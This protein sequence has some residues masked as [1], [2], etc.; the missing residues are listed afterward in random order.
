[1]GPQG[2]PWRAE[3]LTVLTIVTRRHMLRF[4]MFVKMRLCCSQVTTVSAGPWAIY[5]RHFGL[6][7]SLKVSWNM[8]S[9]AWNVKSFFEWDDFSIHGFSGHFWTGNVFRNAHMCNL[10]CQHA[11]SQRVQTFLVCLLQR[12]HSRRISKTGLYQQSFPSTSSS[13]RRLKI[14]VRACISNCAVG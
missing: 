2:I 7:K 9:S 3:F 4:H 14:R 6:N 11:Y 12:N 8:I 5:F 1:M 10:D 13:Q